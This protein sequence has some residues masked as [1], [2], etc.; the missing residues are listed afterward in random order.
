M[1]VGQKGQSPKVRLVGAGILPRPNSGRQP[2]N[3]I[4]YQPDAATGDGSGKGRPLG[5]V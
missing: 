1:E 4:T 3:W 5:L 2:A